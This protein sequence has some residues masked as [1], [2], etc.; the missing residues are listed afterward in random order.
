VHVADVEDEGTARVDDDDEDE[1]DDDEDEEEDEDDDDDDDD[2]AAHP[3]SN[4]RARAPGR[5]RLDPEEEE[6]E[7]GRP[8]RAHG[9][10]WNGGSGGERSWKRWRR[11]FFE[12]TRTQGAR[13]SARDG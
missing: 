9:G 11:L 7:E 4:S 6:E 3:D 8:T 1:D 13:E 5:A 2:D 12:D 10:R